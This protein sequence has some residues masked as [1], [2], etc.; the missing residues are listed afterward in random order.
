MLLLLQLALVADAAA[1]AAGAA[2][3]DDD[4]VLLRNRTVQPLLPATGSAGNSCVRRR[5]RCPHLLSPHLVHR[6]H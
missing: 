3:A 6:E 2:A 5:A 1:T 4:M